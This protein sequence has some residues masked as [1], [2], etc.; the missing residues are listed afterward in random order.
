VSASP[1]FARSEATTQ[2]SLHLQHWIGSLRS[3]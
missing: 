2:S 1:S 3:Q